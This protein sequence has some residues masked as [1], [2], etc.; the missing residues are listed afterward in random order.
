VENG[1]GNSRS[2]T[3]SMWESRK[4]QT[5]RQR[6]EVLES[7]K[8]GRA[9]Q[10]LRLDKTIE[11]KKSVALQIRGTFHMHRTSRWKSARNGG[12]DLE[13]VRGDPSHLRTPEKKK[14]NASGKPR[15]MRKK[16]ELSGRKLSLFCWETQKKK[17]H[18]PYPL[19]GKGCEPTS[20]F[21][22]QHSKLAKG[23]DRGNRIKIR[24]ISCP[25]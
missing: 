2:L 19:I 20:D 25:S 6:A 11:Q 13:G 23:V 21:I 15:H 5:A 7:S 24:T 16:R 1:L 17:K 12:G 10:T 22:Y 9:H 3:T 18:H 8:R 4:T 14:E